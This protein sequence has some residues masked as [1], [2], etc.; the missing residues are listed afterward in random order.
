MPSS[1]TS[2]NRSLSE[3]AKDPTIAEVDPPPCSE[4][5]PLLP[6]LSGNS[7]PSSLSRSG[8]KV[9]SKRRRRESRWPVED[10]GQEPRSTRT[11]VRYLLLLLIILTSSIS[12]AIVIKEAIIGKPQHLEPGRDRS[13]RL[14]PALLAKGRKGGVATENK[15][16]SELGVEVLK[17]GGSAV[18]AAIAST[19]CTGVLNMFSSGIGGG[20][21]MIVRSPYPCPIPSTT[22]TTTSNLTSC[23]N[24]T[25]IDFR[26]TAPSAANETMYKGRPEEAKFGGLSV[27]VPGELRG[28]EQAH[29]RWGRLK[30]ERLVMPS[31]KLAREAKVSKELA[32]RLAYF[33][34]FMKDKPEWAEIFVDPITGELVKE[35][36]TI[37]RESYARTLERIAKEGVDVFYQ[38]SIAESMV[39]KVREEG[40]ILTLED[41]S[42]YRA[43]VKPAIQGSWRGRRV[44]TTQAPTSG[45]VLL[46]LLNL[47]SG[48]PDFP[49]QGPT[50]LSAHRFVE[51]LK[52]GFA[53]RTELADPEFMGREAKRRMAE[54]PTLEEADSI[55][56]KIT[57][58]VT[59]PLEYYGPKFDIQ[60][61]H[62]TMHLSIVDGEG[63][64]VALT[65][66]V[67][68]IFGSRVMDP[69]TGVIMNDE[70]DDTSTPGVANAFGLA[71]SPYNYPEP[72]K[73]PLSSTCP[74]IVENRDGSFRLALGGS[75]GS[76][77]FSSVAQVMLNLD[78]G[79]DLSEAIEAPRI[80]HQLLPVSVSAETGY[81]PK[82][83]HALKAR[84]HEVDMIDVN[85]GVAEVQAVSHVGK[86][87][88]LEVH[89]ASDSRKNGIASAY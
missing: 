16:C 9:K 84:E 87:R 66:T 38:G 11:I 73:R 40:G 12:I 1:S 6:S 32:R 68:L 51:A 48:F 80:H 77:I 57:D 83:L 89:A 5:T 17:E 52:F 27:G 4:T 67:N 74:T 82:L 37:R 28:L 59:H 3:D 78:W 44:F 71:P 58:D 18:D 47:L 85:L 13:G 41:M 33:G 23:A 19:L 30:W 54:I 61:D 29:K 65:S 81:D 63:M 72:G 31:V 8:G 24:H 46:S 7:S 62:G 79:S 60:V 64:A 21:F 69:R 26:E 10:G 36:D 39:E 55:R 20:G 45:P 50:G 43:L 25:T 42:G 22:T 14:N 76:R 56:P 75:G 86:G 88:H 53:Q 49:S 15:V 2:E 35:G 70:L 34:G